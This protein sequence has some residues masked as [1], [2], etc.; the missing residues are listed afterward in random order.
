MTRLGQRWTGESDPA[1]LRQA[2]CWQQAAEQES[3]AVVSHF[4]SKAMVKPP[5]FSRLPDAFF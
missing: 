5:A 3:G 1:R 4:P 2:A